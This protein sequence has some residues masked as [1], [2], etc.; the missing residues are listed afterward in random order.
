MSIEAPSSTDGSPEHRRSIEC[1]PSV[2]TT[3]SASIAN[4]TVRRLRPNAGNARARP[5][6]VGRFD[7][8]FEPKPRK[9]ASSFRE[10][11]QEIPLR[12]DCDEL[13]PAGD[14]AEVG[15]AHESPSDH[16]VELAQLRMRDP[17]EVVEEPEF[18]EHLQH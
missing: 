15:G 5:N 16:A 12:H 1:R 6:Q 10:K 13:A 17:Q 3:S 8:H 4:E 18:I 7:I 9:P 14:V 11:V 2:A